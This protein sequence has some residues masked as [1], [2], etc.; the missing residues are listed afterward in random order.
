MSDIKLFS[1][2]ADTVH[3]GT[4]DTIETL[5]KP[6]DLERAHR[7]SDAAMKLHDRALRESK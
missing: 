3:E 2:T 7:S 4:T 5:T 1:V 6:D